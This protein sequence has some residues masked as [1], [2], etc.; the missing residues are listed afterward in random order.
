MNETM[1]TK[2]EIADAEACPEQAVEKEKPLWAWD[3]SI[4]SQEKMVEK[5][6][7]ELTS[8]ELKDYREGH[9]KGVVRHM[10]RLAL[11]SRKCRELHSNSNFLSHY[12][13][14][15]GRECCLYVNGDVVFVTVPGRVPE[16]KRVATVLSLDEKLKSHTNSQIR[17]GNTQRTKR[18]KRI[19]SEIS[20]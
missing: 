8:R 6:S 7:A 15:Y 5:F 3:F 19:R 13:K 18:V 12:R 10:E 9:P 4:H 14:R 1:D 16:Q 20:Y 11:A 17:R 2:F